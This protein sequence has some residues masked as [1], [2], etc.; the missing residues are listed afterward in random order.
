MF[1]V[2]EIKAPYY[3]LVKQEKHALDDL[4]FTTQLTLNVNMTSHL[5]YKCEFNIEGIGL[6]SDSI[7]IH[8]IGMF[9]QI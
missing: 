9:W 5:D 4:E 3:D 7:F 2:D 8:F 6:C 1:Q